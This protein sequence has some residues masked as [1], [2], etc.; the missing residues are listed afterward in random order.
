M[1][2]LKKKRTSIILWIVT[3]ITALIILIPIYWIFNSSLKSTSDLFST[4]IEWFGSSLT[5]NNYKR[6]FTQ[7][8]IIQQIKNTLIITS[9]TLLICTLFCTIG[10]YSFNRNKSRSVSLVFAFIIF[11]SLIPA[12]VTARPLYDYMNKLKLVNTFT[13]LIVL[14]T[15]SLIPFT[16]LVLKNFLDGIPVAIDEAAEIDGANT[17]QKL[18]FVIIPLM[19]PAIST[20][21]IINFISCLNEFFIPLIFSSNI[22]LLSTGIATVPRTNSYDVPWDLLSAMGCVILIPIIIFVVLFE[23]KILDGIMAGGIKS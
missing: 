6:L 15:S 11:S 12:I 19:K 5:L 3:I 2:Y 16:T 17:I 8:N 20:V 1:R 4:P 18:W 22:E 23:K 10:A 13:G 14:Y 9:F 7:T 21:C